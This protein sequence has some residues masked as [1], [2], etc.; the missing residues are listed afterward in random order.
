M[1]ITNNDSGIDTRKRE[2]RAHDTRRAAL[3]TALLL[4]AGCATS[5]PLRHVE[6]ET[7]HGT[8]GP[9]SLLLLNLHENE[10]TSVEAARQYLAETDAA[11][12]VLVKL[13]H[14]GERNLSFQLGGA[15]YRVDPN[16]IFSDGGTE[17]SIRALSDSAQATRAEQA[18]EHVRGLATELLRSTSL[19]RA[20]YVIALHNNTDANY[21]SASYLPDSVYAA[22]AADVSLNPDRDP[23]DFFFVTESWLFDGLAERGF[24]VVLQA[25]PAEATDDGSLSVYAGAEGIGY[26]NVEAQHG[27]LD[28]QVEMLRAL[29]PLLQDRL[30]ASR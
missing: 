5:D 15:T 7:L 3:L 6:I 14:Q 11:S 10:S 2:G 30:D 20:R 18:T 1:V 24:N 12:A 17:R 27:H 25:P 13:G 19:D 29:V 8:P 28:E 9:G 4:L 16:R 22:E 26:V 23:D 21:Q